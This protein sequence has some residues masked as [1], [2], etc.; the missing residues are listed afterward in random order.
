MDIVAMQEF[1]FDQLEKSLGVSFKNQSLLKKA[2]VHRSFLN[3][4]PSELESNERLE[5]LGDAVLEFI[6]S[7]ILFRDFPSEDEG[8]LT[9]LRS[10]LVNTTSLAATAKQLNLGTM[11]FLV[12]WRR[13]K[14]RA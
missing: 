11:L 13:K 7:E 6:I 14:R 3:E 9:V 5:F 2:L 10:R 1:N 12:S 4:N 8:H